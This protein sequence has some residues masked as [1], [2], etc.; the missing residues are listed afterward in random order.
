MSVLT[1]YGFVRRK[2]EIVGQVETRE[3]T[4]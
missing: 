4:I 2:K 1:S 3:W